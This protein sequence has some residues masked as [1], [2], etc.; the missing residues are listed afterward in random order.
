MPQNITPQYLDAQATSANLG[1]IKINYSESDTVTGGFIVVE[2]R[3]AEGNVVESETVNFTA[4]QFG[5]WN[6]TA[7]Q[8]LNFALNNS[9]RLA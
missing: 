6:G 8:A 1:F 9:Q 3:D 4:A 7:S 2:Y 5:N